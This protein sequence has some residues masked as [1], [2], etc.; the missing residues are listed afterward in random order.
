MIYGRGS[1]TL[2]GYPIL[3]SYFLAATNHINDRIEDIT[4]PR[5]CISRIIVLYFTIHK[6]ACSTLNIK[7]SQWYSYF[8]SS[9]SLIFRTLF[10]H[11]NQDLTAFN[12]FLLETNVLFYQNFFNNIF[13]EVENDAWFFI[14]TFSYYL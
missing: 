5:W 9:Q 3:Q 4:I 14:V 2:I 12:F 7:L 10:G 11:I 8:S 1:V 6:V 13:F